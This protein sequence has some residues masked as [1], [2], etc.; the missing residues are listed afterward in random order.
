[1]ANLL[2]W[3]VGHAWT[4]SLKQLKLQHKFIKALSDFYLHSKNLDNPQQTIARAVREKLQIC[5]LSTLC[6]PMHASPPQPKINFITDFHHPSNITLR[7]TQ[8]FDWS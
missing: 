4:N 8:P 5:Y 2:Y 3:V 6:M 7:R 1:M